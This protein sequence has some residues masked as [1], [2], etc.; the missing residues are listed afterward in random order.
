[1]VKHQEEH[2]DCWIVNKNLALGVL[3]AFAIPL[4][5]SL[6]WVGA[7]YANVS[8]NTKKIEKIEQIVHSLPAMQRDIEWLRKFLERQAQ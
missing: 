3:A 5:C 8:E 1:M 6:I 4:I 7:L 2:G